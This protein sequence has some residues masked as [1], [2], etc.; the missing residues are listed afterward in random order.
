MKH[1]QDHQGT[2]DRSGSMDSMDYVFQLHHVGEALTGH[3]MPTT[4]EI[5]MARKNAPAKQSKTTDIMGLLGSIAAPEASS[6]HMGR[7][8]VPLLD[9][10]TYDQLASQ[11]EQG[12]VTLTGGVHFKSDAILTSV[13]HKLRAALSNKRR[14]NPIAVSI[15]KFEAVHRDREAILE[16]C[17]IKFAEFKTEHGKAVPAANQKAYYEAAIAE[18]EARQDTLVLTKN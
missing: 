2:I 13:V 12:E 1:E 17:K 11:L 10:T 15:G 14:A 6:G 5:I 3:V 8:P 9:G 16:L 4:R 18:D 7:P